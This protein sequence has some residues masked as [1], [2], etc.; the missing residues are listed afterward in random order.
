MKSKNLMKVSLA[1]LLLA[2][3]LLEASAFTVTIDA[4]HGGNGSTPGKRFLDGE[5]YEWDINDA[6]ADKLQPMLESKG[7]TVHR[8]DDATGQSDISLNSRLYQAINIGSDLHISVHQNSAG[9]ENWCEATGTEVY[10]STLGSARSIQL[11]KETANRMSEYIQ[12][13][14]R[15]AKTNNLFITREFTNANIDA[16]LVEGLFMDNYEDTRYMMSNEYAQ[17]YA[18]AIA[19]S[20]YNTYRSQINNEPFQIQVRKDLGETLN[21]RKEPNATSE[22]VGEVNPGEVFTIVEVKGNFGKLASGAGWI[23]ISMK[24]T[25]NITLN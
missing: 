16:I 18:Q 25:N 13:R 11:A 12:T 17:R 4:G 20:I 9:A 5:R 7:I 24:F 14:N 2:S 21:I 10:Y 3:P 6:V 19:D 8:L 15:G 22:I 23:N 1:S